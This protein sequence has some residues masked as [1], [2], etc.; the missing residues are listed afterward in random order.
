MGRS[1]IRFERPKG[2]IESVLGNRTGLIAERDGMSYDTAQAHYLYTE[3]VHPLIGAT[4]KGGL[5]MGDGSPDEPFMPVLFVEQ[6]GKAYSLVISADDE[7]NDG[8]RVLIERG[9]IIMGDISATQAVR[10]A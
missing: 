2:S 8:G 1:A 10:G 6:N 9:H 5:V 7:C 4:I 3:M